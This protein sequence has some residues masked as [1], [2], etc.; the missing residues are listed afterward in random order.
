[1]PVYLFIKK[2]KK[3]YPNGDSLKINIELGF[4]EWDD[5]HA[6]KRVAKFLGKH[7]EY[8]TDGGETEKTPDGKKAE[9]TIK[10][11]PETEFLYRFDPNVVN[12]KRQIFP[13]EETTHYNEYLD[14][15]YPGDE[16]SV[17]E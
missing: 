1:M 6:V 9:E 11:D 5:K 15:E 10:L 14:K 7:P 12:G 17:D 16:L 3:N 2:E 13:G 8:E 4:E